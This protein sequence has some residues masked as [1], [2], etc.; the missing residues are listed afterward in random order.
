MLEKTKYFLCML[1]I[2]F[3]IGVTSNLYAQLVPR[4]LGAAGLVLDS[5][6]TPYKAITIDVPTTL[7]VSYPLHLPTVPPSGPLSMLASDVNGVMVW[8]ASGT[9]SLPP[10]PPGNIWVGNAL[11]VAMPYA[12]TV[13]G[14][15]MTLNGS[16]T[17]TWSTVIPSNT[18]ISVSQLT[19][20][21]LQSGVTFNVGTGS[22]INVTGGT[23]TS[24]NLVGAG[25]GNYAGTVAI[26]QNAVSLAIPYTPI[27]AGSSVMVNIIDPGLPGVAIYLASITPGT[28]F[29]VVFSAPYPTNTGKV[30]YHIVNP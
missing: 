9:A 7:T 4:L 14:A 12:P 1:F 20:G 15:V 13:P 24:N 21:T 6:S 18:T 5:R 8:T 27:Q 30:S 23:N 11:S 22:T 25:P 29:S 17:P 28:G 16:S 19:T 3:S 2:A 10:L 26:P